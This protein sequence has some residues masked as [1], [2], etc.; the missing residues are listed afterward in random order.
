[1]KYYL[2]SKAL[3]AHSKL[4]YARSK[5]LDGHPKVSNRDLFGAKIHFSIEINKYL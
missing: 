1:M 3:D 2:R 5:A 4:L